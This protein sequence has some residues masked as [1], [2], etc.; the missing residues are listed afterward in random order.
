M[1][2]TLHY[3]SQPMVRHVHHNTHVTLASRFAFY[4]TNRR[5][6]SGVCNMQC[7]SNSVAS[8]ALTAK[9]HGSM[10]AVLQLIVVN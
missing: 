3:E 6:K 1:V 9:F 7:Y 5:N 2:Y 10:L 4:R 8:S